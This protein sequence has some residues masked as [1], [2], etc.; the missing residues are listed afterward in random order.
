MLTKK[1]SEFKNLARYEATRKSWRIKKPDVDKYPYVFSVSNGI[2]REIYKVDKWKETNG[3][4]FYFSGKEVSD[5]L[6]SNY[7][8]KDFINKR[9]PSYYL[10]KGMASPVL[11]S[12]NIILK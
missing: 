3:G 2:V 1:R 11:Y 4:R 7:K 8:K 12:K 9:I 10:K 6:G 5:K